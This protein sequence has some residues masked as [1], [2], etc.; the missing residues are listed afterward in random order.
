[1]NGNDKE[2]DQEEYLQNHLYN[3]HFILDLMKPEAKPILF[4]LTDATCSLMGKPISGKLDSVISKLHINDTKIITIDLGDENRVTNN[5]GY[6]NHDEHLK[7]LAYVSL[8]AH[9]EYSNFMKLSGEF[10]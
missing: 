10:T 3:S 5:F 2:E 6:V 8:G 1:M 4:L 9:F 7:Y